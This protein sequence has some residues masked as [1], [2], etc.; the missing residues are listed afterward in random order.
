MHNELSELGSFP[1]KAL[2]NIFHLNELM[3][4]SIELRITDIML[5]GVWV[6]FMYFLFEK[7]PEHY[8]WSHEIILFISVVTG[9]LFLYADDA[10]V[11]NTCLSTLLL[12]AVKFNDIFRQRG[13]NTVVPV[14]A[15]VYTLHHYNKIVLKAIEHIWGKF[16]LLNK[17]VFVMQAVTSVA[18]L[19]CPRANS[20]EG[21]T[22]PIV[23]KLID[24]PIS[25]YP[26][27][28]LQRAQAVK[29]IFKLIKSLSKHQPDVL[30]I[31]VRLNYF[32]CYL[33]LSVL[34]LYRPRCLCR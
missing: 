28:D 6:H 31:E 7:M 30:G 33:L 21:E 10:V 19:L 20:L 23:V 9:S 8:T 4:P 32:I 22:Q 34:Y 18:M 16:Y 1:R 29:A 2:D 25:N 11:L 13:Y 27:N 24:G 26:H 17:N 15:Q 12:A 3:P 5:K 14:L